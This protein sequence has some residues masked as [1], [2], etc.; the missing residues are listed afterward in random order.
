M[1]KGGSMMEGNI[2]KIAQEGTFEEFYSV[3]KGDINQMSNDNMN[4]LNV[5]LTSNSLLEE[6]VKIVQFL[7]NEGID[8]NY[9]DSDKRNVLHNFFQYKANWRVNVKYALTILTILLE[10]GIDINQVD[11]Y[12]SIPLIYAITVPKLPTEEAMPIYNLLID[13][14][15]DTNL[16]NFQGKS[17][18]DYAREFSWRHGLLSENGGPLYDKE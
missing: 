15:S 1:N 9:L 6:K 17:A 18:V 11:K 12:G 5:V 4:L 2:F 10:S 8:V 13:S 3:F 14:G 16:K 7:V